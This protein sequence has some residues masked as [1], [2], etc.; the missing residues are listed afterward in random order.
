MISGLVM[1]A[2]TCME[3]PHNGD[4]AKSILKDSLESL[5]PS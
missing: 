2:I 4:M 3:S 5:S 1:S